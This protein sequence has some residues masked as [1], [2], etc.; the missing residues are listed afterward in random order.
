MGKPAQEGVG[1]G[2]K[3]MIMQEAEKQ[4]L[5]CPFCGMKARIMPIRKVRATH[6]KKLMGIRYAVGCSDP[7]CIL[8]SDGRTRRLVFTCI[9]CRLLVKRWNRRRVNNDCTLPV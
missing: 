5:P 1:D 9:D 3:K 2:M 8:F 7:D 4:L 6:V